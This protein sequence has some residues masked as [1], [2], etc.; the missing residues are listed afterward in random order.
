MLNRTLS[1]SNLCRELR[2]RTNA[3]PANVRNNVAALTS[4]IRP[5]HLLGE[6]AFVF[7]STGKA[8]FPM[9]PRPMPGAKSKPGHPG[10]SG[11]PWQRSIPGRCRES[12]LGSPLLA[13]APP[14]WREVVETP[15]GGSDRRH[16]LSQ[17]HVFRSLLASE[18]CLDAGRPRYSRASLAG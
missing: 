5:A 6:P 8:G 3:Q 10:S 16:A 9:H 15:P 14:A 4:T 18:R 12:L 2:A 11:D 7:E 17:A 1:A 13:E